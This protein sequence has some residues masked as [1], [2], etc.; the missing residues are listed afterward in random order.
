MPKRDKPTFGS[1]TIAGKM[2]CFRRLPSLPMT[3]LLL[4]AVVLSPA[5]ETHESRG[6]LPGSFGAFGDA[7]LY[8]AG[9]DRVDDTLHIERLGS[10]E[11]SHC[12]GCLLRENRSGVAAQR[13]HT[14]RAGVTKP[15]YAPAAERLPLAP[16]RLD[17]APRAPPSHFSR[18]S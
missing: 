11:A 5:F 10:I 9:H 1:T 8:V 18:S 16:P 4:A 6:H 17:T 13:Q 2:P 12:V 7:A 3:L 15:A 14:A